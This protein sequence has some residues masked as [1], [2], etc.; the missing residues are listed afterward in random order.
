MPENTRLVKAMETTDQVELSWSHFRRTGMAATSAGNAPMPAELHRQAREDKSAAPTQPAKQLSQL[1]GA[2]NMDQGEIEHHAEAD[3][4]GQQARLH[5]EWRAAGKIGA[6]A[7]GKE[8]KRG[9][10]EGADQEDQPVATPF[11]RGEGE[12]A[13]PR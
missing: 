13:A 5:P 10:H 8:I 3:Q 11:G 4:H 7:L 12:M 6:A 9:P 1:L 2:G